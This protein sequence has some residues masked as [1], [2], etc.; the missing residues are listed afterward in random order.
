MAAADAPE[1][2]PY[3]Y[4]AYRFSAERR[5]LHDALLHEVYDDYCGQTSWTPADQARS[6][7]L[8]RDRLASH[9]LAR[10]RHLL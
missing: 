2:H 6:V 10:D 7:A 8:H 4:Y 5:G 9:E 3:D 1:G